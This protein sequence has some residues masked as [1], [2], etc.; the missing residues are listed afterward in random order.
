MA[1]VVSV[2]S[3][4]LAGKKDPVPPPDFEQRALTGTTSLE[5]RIIAT[6]EMERL[7]DQ[8]LADLEVLARKEGQHAELSRYIAALL[9]RDR[10]GDALNFLQER[11]WADQ[12]SETKL[13]DL[14][15]LAM[16][17]LRWSTCADIALTRLERRMD[18]TLF[19]IRALCLRRSGDPEQAAENLAASDSME[20]LGRDFKALVTAQ[21]E[22]RAA[23]NQLPPAD[24]AVYGPFQAKY[25]RRGAL[26]KLLVF[27]FLNRKD[28]GWVWGTIDWGG[29]G[30]SELRQVILSRS[31]SYR[32][33][34]EAATR[35]GKRR[36][37][38]LTGS[39]TVVW[40]IDAL[41]RVK[42]P[43]LVDPDWG[44][45]EQGDW[46]NACL[47]DQVQRLRFPQTFYGLAMPARHR[48][49]F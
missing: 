26:E 47:I 13:A 44:G 16:G 42:E 37:K 31:R 23:G 12:A 6:I 14:L 19:L 18:S 1:L 34:H 24:D 28:P 21:L 30:A 46:L 2:P 22:E 8:E 3:L 9:G 32:Y 27:H 36:K 39:A 4:A 45:H 15:D 20:P 10:L 7:T 48:F 17:Q 33:C 29:F 40:R 49:S 25:G 35:Q 11:S 41:G 38:G 43:K 5:K